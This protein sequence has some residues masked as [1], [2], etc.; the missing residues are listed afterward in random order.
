MGFK[1]FRFRVHRVTG[2][3]SEQGL[4]LETFNSVGTVTSH[5]TSTSFE[6]DS[7]GVEC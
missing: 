2:T 5:A 3:G 6:P 7:T 1:A 4:C